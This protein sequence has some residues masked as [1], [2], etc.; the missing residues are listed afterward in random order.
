M[1]YD[2]EDDDNDD[3]D[4]N[5]YNKMISSLIQTLGIFTL[6]Q[7]SLSSL[8]PKQCFLLFLVKYYNIDTVFRFGCAFQ[9]LGERF[10]V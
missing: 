8:Y 3:D 6:S 10:K 1:K 9:T 4:N 5:N 2:N 7:I